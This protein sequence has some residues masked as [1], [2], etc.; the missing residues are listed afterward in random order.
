MFFL[1]GLLLQ[2]SAPALPTSPAPLSF[3]DA[4]LSS[5]PFGFLVFEFGFLIFVEPAPPGPGVVSFTCSSLPSTSSLNAGL[6]SAA[7]PAVQP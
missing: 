3:P 2:Y 6:S 5:I 7:V 4:S 1:L